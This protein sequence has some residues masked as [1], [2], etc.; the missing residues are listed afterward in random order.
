MK[1]KN[2]SEIKKE[3]TWDLT[4]IFKNEKDFFKELETVKPLLSKVTEY[5]GKLLESDEMLLSF[6]E[7]SDD[8]ERR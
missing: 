3:D 1:Q 4:Y 8:I 5:K 2:R 6:L 7:F